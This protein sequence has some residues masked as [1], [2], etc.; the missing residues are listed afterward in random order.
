MDKQ[1]RGRE[2]EGRGK[3]GGREGE[4]E[5][6]EKD[7]GGFTTGNNPSVNWVGEGREGRGRS[8]SGMRTQ[9][10][11][12]SGPWP[13][14]GRRRCWLRPST[15]PPPHPG[16]TPGH[17]PPPTRVSAFPAAPSTPQLK[18]GSSSAEFAEFRKRLAWKAFQVRGWG[19]ERRGWERGGRE[20]IRGRQGWGATEWE[21]NEGTR[22]GGWEGEAGRGR[23][24]GRERGDSG[25]TV[26][27]KLRWQLE[28]GGNWEAAGGEAKAAGERA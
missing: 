17:T 12:G 15:P 28:G 14:A 25:R 7:K 5:G 3:G 21:G 10:V 9:R 11:D 16:H 22:G 2:G 19:R 23:G 8:R 20:W 4:G 6:E 18:K 24:K 26:E 1:G 13:F 27:G